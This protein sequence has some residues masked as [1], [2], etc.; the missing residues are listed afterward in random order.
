MTALT[1]SLKPITL[2]VRC[3][4]MHD[5]LP[6]Q[7]L[8][9]LANTPSD[10]DS[11]ISLASSHRVL[12]L[13]YR[14]LKRV[15][16]SGLSVEALQTLRAQY[17]GNA[18]RNLF[19]THVLQ[20]MLRSLRAESIDCLP[21]KGPVVAEAYYEDLSLRA[22]GDLD[23]IIREKDLT[24]A[25]TLAARAGYQMLVELKG[26][27][28]KRY[29]RDRHHFQWVREDGQVTLEIHWRCIQPCYAF[30]LHVDDLLARR[31]P[32]DLHKETVLA[33][34][35]ED[36]LL[37]LCL[38]GTK[39]CWQDLGYIADIDALLRSSAAKRL[40]WTLLQDIAHEVGGLRMLALGL[41]LAH[42]L[43]QSP[44]PQ[45]GLDWL[46]KQGKADEIAC[47]VL[48]RLLSDNPSRRNAFQQW[49]FFLDARER[50][51]DRLIGNWRLARALAPSLL[52]PKKLRGVWKGEFPKT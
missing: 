15:A 40:N 16:S 5:E 21:L 38:H 11:L 1:H 24:Q 7:E 22:F 23:I 9:Q 14:S 47:S 2:L 33:P 49:S 18:A 29:L 19:L 13:L 26:Q 48:G 36:H 41:K 45:V 35:H 43:F 34:S 20:G 46:E 37:I 17:F 44:L 32:L 12:P 6:T 42:N 51:I 28:L 30:P 39:N 25:S 3:L 52:R 27:I 4:R 8:S 10:W 50:S 31:I